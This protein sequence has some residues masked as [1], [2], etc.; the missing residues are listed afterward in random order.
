MPRFGVPKLAMTGVVVVG[1][2]EISVFSSRFSVSGFVGS[3]CFVRGETGR[4]RPSATGGEET[5]GDPDGGI[6][7]ELGLDNGG[8]GGS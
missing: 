3:A 6:L 8:V 1:V 5:G 7:K 4:P 2:G